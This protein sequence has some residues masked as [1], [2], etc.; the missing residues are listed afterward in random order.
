MTM[1]GMTEVE[2]YIAMD[3]QGHDLDAPT[4]DYGSEGDRAGRGRAGRAGRNIMIG[5]R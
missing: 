4:A 2:I 3:R 5:A 1:S